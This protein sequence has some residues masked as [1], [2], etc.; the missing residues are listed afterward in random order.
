ML[1]VEKEALT[2]LDNTDNAEVTGESVL[3]TDEDDKIVTNADTMLNTKPLLSSSYSI[4]FPNDDNLH[5]SGYRQTLIW[6]YD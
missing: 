5:T 6:H 2:E 4:S 1:P 3:A